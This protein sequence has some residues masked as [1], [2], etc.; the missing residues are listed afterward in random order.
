MSS[1]SLPLRPV[2][3]PPQQQDHQEH[4][5][6]ELPPAAADPQPLPPIDEQG[7]GPL[8]PPPAAVESI[9]ASVAR[10]INATSGLQ[11]KENHQF[12]VNDSKIA[13]NLFTIHRSTR[14][15]QDFTSSM[16]GNHE[17]FMGHRPVPVMSDGDVLFM[18]QLSSDISRGVG[19]ISAIRHHGLSAAKK[20]KARPEGLPRREDGFKRL[21][22]S[23]RSHHHH[24]NS[25]RAATGKLS[26]SSAVDLETVDNEAEGSLSCWKCGRTDTPQWRKGSDGEVLCN[27]C[28]LVSAKQKKK[29]KD[30]STHYSHSGPS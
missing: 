4:P 24:Q 19:T 17:S 3:P 20:R 27:A 1:F 26:S 12:W 10:W 18:T 7:V 28:G 11:P 2:A 9:K 29:G 6:A 25:H 21:H 5:Q 8:S 22:S 15:L 23:S 14:H 30:K 16:I 13:E